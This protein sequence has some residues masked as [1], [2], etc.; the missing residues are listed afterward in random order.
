MNLMNN[1]FDQS[2]LINLEPKLATI[3]IS[4]TSDFLESD[5]FFV[6]ISWLIRL[7]ANHCADHLNV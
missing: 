4:K 2:V 1:V 6:P 5:S 3:I 7:L